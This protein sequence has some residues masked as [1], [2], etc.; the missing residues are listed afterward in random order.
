MNFFYVSNGHIFLVLAFEL[1]N[2]C[3]GAL[4]SLLIYFFVFFLVQND[5]EDMIY[6]Y[7]AY[8]HK[9]ITCFLSHPLALDKVSWPDLS[10]FANNYSLWV[11]L[12]VKNVEEKRIFTWKLY[13]EAFLL[14]GRGW[15]VCFCFFHLIYFI[16]WAFSV[17]RGCVYI[18]INIS[19][20]IE[21]V[22]LYIGAIYWCTS[23]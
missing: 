3:T 13:L 15:A 7:D 20:L 5:D 6:M 4:V 10:V 16:H 2:C 11:R 22:K 12:E 18:F 19:F 9:L 23:Y 14:A 17:S 8:L 1:L 21:E